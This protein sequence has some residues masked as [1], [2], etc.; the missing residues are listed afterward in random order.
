MIFVLAALTAL[1]MSAGSLE[2][3]LRMSGKPPA[4]YILSRLANHRIV[5]LGENHWQRN[6]V[7][8]VK[9]LLPDLRNQGIVFAAEVFQVERQADIDR[10]LA[11]SEWDVNL[12]HDIL[13]SSYWPY[14]Q[15]REILEVAWKTNRVASKS[16]PLRVVAIG[17]PYDF[18]EKKIRY[19]Q[20]MVEHLLSAMPS[21]ES[22]AL[23][24]VGMH[25]AFTRYLQIDRREGGRPS[26]FM[27]R[28]G[29]IL[30]RRFA[31]NVFLIALHKPD[32]CGPVG[33]GASVLCVPFGGQIDCAGL[34]VGKPT[35]FDV[36]ESP[37]AELKFPEAS[38]YASGHPLLRFID[39][40]DG[41]IW[42]GPIDEV[43]LVDLIPLDEWSPE[44]M[45]KLGEPA[46]WQKRAAD[47]ANPYE[48]RSWKSLKGWRTA[49]GEGH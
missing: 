8:L 31:E 47:L 7:E 28:F 39:Y 34:A 16:P 4:D 20:F 35:G 27:D 41:Y 11:A 38:F 33:E 18:R 2:Q 5:I 46:K 44:G 19:D 23:A 32:W 26:E 29:N 24:Y 22:H 21:K 42:T 17:P 25:H 30:W 10:L 45:T 40:A 3:Y 49:C 36:L 37:I 43:R 13:R 1:T 15:Y 9:R 14:V 48:R 6:D 12:A